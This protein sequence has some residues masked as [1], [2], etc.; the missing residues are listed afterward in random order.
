MTSGTPD[1]LPRIAILADDL[2]W[3]TRLA[4]AVRRAG[5]EAMPVR[6]AA[7][8]SGALIAADGCL[9]D[10]TARA[11]DGL[12]ALREAAESG[13]PSVAVGQHDD[14]DGRRAARA[15]GAARVYAYRTLFE[16]GDREL[17]AWIAGLAAGLEE[18][19]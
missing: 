9:V 7:A 1:R 5:G 6:N 4:D 10:L 14:A 15:A 8:L 12:A 16:H 2:M 17:G 13:V 19:R 3:A 18:E 11:Y